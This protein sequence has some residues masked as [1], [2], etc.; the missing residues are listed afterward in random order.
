MAQKKVIV[1]Y[2]REYPGAYAWPCYAVLCP[3]CGEMATRYGDSSVFI[4]GEEHLICTPCFEA[5]EPCLISMDEYRE[6]CDDLSRWENE[7]GPARD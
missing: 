7:G 3:E 6:L 1:G 5:I 4:D 2:D